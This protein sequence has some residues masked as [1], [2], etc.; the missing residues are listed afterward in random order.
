MSWVEVVQT[1]SFGQGRP[2]SMRCIS[3]ERIFSRSITSGTQ[4]G[5]IPRSSPQA[6]IPVHES[7]AG[8][9]SMAFLRQNALCLW[10]KK[11]V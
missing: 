3:S 5:T 11:S 7:S 9:L 2:L 6:S 4:S 1:L 8:S 10:K